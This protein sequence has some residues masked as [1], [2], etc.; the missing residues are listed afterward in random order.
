[1][2]KIA[3]FA[4]MAVHMPPALSQSG[5]SV[6]SSSMNPAAHVGSSLQRKAGRAASDNFEP[7]INNG[8]YW[9]QQQVCKRQAA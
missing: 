1:M 6:N 4:A 8:A 5:C 2:L 3:L 9:A 7:K